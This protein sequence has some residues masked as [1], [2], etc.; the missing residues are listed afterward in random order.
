MDQFSLAAHLLSTH[1]GY[2]EVAWD[3]AGE[4]LT[5]GADPREVFVKA[6]TSG[7]EARMNQAHEALAR[8]SS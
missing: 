1:G 7:F 5:E 8:R 6:S 3:V 4:I 2:P